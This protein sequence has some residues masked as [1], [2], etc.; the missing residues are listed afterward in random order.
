MKLAV[1]GIIIEGDRSVAEIV[2]K[3]LSEYG[4]YIVCRMG[5]PDRANGIF[6]ISVIVRA[7]IEKISALSG[8]LGKLPNVKVKAAVTDAKS[9]S[10]PDA[11]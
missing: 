8:K 10:P 3:I 2:N 11:E 1:I 6:V 7:E 9:V 4:D 5:V